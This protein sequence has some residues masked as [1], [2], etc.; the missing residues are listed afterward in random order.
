M[1]IDKSY[2]ELALENIHD[3]QSKEEIVSLVNEALKQAATDTE[4][5]V[6]NTDGNVTIPQSKNSMVNFMSS[7]EKLLVFNS[8]KQGKVLAKEYLKEM[9]N[10]A[11]SQNVDDLVIEELNEFLTMFD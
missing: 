4:D 7:V 6:V 8:T 11:A 3:G 10:F 9:L 5:V 2:L 1:S